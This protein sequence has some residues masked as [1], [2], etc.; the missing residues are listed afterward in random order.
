[1]IPQDMGRLVEISDGY[2]IEYVGP[3]LAG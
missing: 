2:G 3:P 1:V